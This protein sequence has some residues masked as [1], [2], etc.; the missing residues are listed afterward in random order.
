MREK[1]QKKRKKE[2][3]RKTSTLH[4]PPLLEEFIK[5]VA[6]WGG[7]G[8]RGEADEKKKMTCVDRSSSYS[9][10]FFFFFLRV[11][12]TIPTY[13]SSA[14]S[15]III[16]VERRTYLSHQ[17]ENWISFQSSTSI[18][19]VHTFLFPYFNNKE[20]NKKKKKKFDYQFQCQCWCC[21]TLSS[22][23]LPFA[24]I[25]LLPSSCNDV[26]SFLPPLVT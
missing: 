11:M 3:G 8:W 7:V 24:F 13:K 10:S 14:V 2:G 20:K 21:C 22:S 19:G 1:Y 23:S 9:E 6:G 25:T 18:G 4:L 16:G 26:A 17:T 15:L 5:D 12:Q